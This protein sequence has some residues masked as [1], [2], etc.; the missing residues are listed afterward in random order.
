M[1]GK[2]AYIDNSLSKRMRALMTKHKLVEIDM[3]LLLDVSKTSVHRWLHDAAP[4]HALYLRMTA[5]LNDLEKLDVIKAPRKAVRH[6]A[7][8]G[9]AATQTVR[10]KFI[11]ARAYANMTQTAAAEILKCSQVEL[12]RFERGVHTWL[13]NKDI[14]A[15]IA[16][17]GKQATKS[18]S[19]IVGEALK[20]EVIEIITDLA[21][22]LHIDSD[23]SLK[24]IHQFLEFGISEGMD[25]NAI[26]AVL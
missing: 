2:I 3:A 23:K 13:D 22:V 1:A 16:V 14:E 26:A 7:T 6:I 25:F 15:F 10:D 20:A 8:R 18:D 12:S 11:Q 24:L 9:V 19:E 21:G 5:R 17:Y 4:N